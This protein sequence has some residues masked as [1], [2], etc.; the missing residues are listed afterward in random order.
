[1]YADSMEEAD[2]SQNPQ[3]KCIRLTGRVVLPTDPGF[4]KARLVSN[5][6]TSKNKQPNAIVYC[7]CAQDVQNAVK[8]ARCNSLNVHVRSGGH[9][10][11]GYSTG[12]NALVIDVSEMKQLHIDKEK[13]IITV[14]PGLTNGELYSKLYT[15]GLT[16]VGGTCADVGI[17]GFMLSGGMGPLYKRHG[18]G[19]DNLLYLEMVDAN[20]NL[21]KATKDNEHKDLFWACQGGGAGNFGV[22]TLMKIQV[23][24]ADNVTWFNIG[25]DWNQPIN[26][27]IAGWQN[28]FYKADENWFSHIDIWSKGFPKESKKQPVK[29]LGVY[30]GTPEQARQELAP[31]LQIGK[32][33]DEVIKTV[34]WI[35]AIQEFEDST[36]VFITDRPEYKSSGAYVMQDLPKDAINT[37]TSTLGKSRAPLFN[38]LMFSFA[39]SAIKAAPNDT[40][41]YYRDAKA[42][43]SI[44]NQWLNETDDK[45]Q[46]A[47]LDALRKKLQP[48]IEGDY[49]GNPDTTFKDYLKEYY[50]ANVPKLE[51]IKL[52]YDPDNVF[53]YL[54]SIP[55]AKES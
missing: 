8:W 37:I 16:Q 26:Q 30:W 36:S 52:K 4:E 45:E 18:L 2:K 23:Y 14:Q 21:I 47:A 49:I 39:D 9:N 44:S 1:M 25:W 7:Q 10:H 22:I 42:F 35:E 24:P 12:D 46:L 6:Y 3:D 34:T 48:F 43:M 15:V 5:Y 17:S 28:F 20:G 38:I 31:L 55:P 13:K 29:I 53:R 32:P 40:A 33:T 27:V 41:Y 54:Q 50:G 11:E 51:Q 19:C